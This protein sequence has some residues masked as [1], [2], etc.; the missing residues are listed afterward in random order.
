MIRPMLICWM[1]SGSSDT[2]GLSVL[3]VRVSITHPRPRTANGPRS[4]RV[5]CCARLP[6]HSRP[7][8]HTTGGN[9]D[10]AL[11]SQHGRI[12]HR[13]VGLSR[14]GIA[15]ARLGNVTR[16]HFRPVVVQSET[17][18]FGSRTNHHTPHTLGLFHGVADTHCKYA[19]QSSHTR[20]RSRQ[21]G[22]YRVEGCF[23]VGFSN[24]DQTGTDANRG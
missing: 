12:C 5:R 1:S 23:H 6:G 13:P 24:P 9:L 17:T 4:E 15:R 10:R 19:P 7:G 14:A 2:L 8:C 16:R 21:G 18:M 22:F 3:I 11:L 20:P